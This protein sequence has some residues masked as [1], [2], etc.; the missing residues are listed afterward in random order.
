MADTT[1]AIAAAPAGAA[2]ANG[3][4]ISNPQPA[5]LQVDIGLQRDRLV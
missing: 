5:L 3:W 4:T 1:L 2:P